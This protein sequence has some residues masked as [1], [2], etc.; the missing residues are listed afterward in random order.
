MRTSRRAFMRAGV[1]TGIAGVLPVGGKAAE[2]GSAARTQLHKALIAPL[3]DD[4]TCARLA[5][6]GFSG[7]ELTKKDVTLEQGV[8]GRLTAEKHGIRI[9]SFMAGWADF[10]QEDEG[11]RNASIEDV[12]RMIRLTAAYGASTMLLVP[13]RIGGMAMPRPTQFQVEFDADTLTVRRVAEGDNAPYE[14]YIRAQNRAT[15]LSRQ[16]IEALLPVAARE[17]VLIAVEN[18]WNNLWVTPELL[19]AFVRSFDS[20]WVKTYFDLGNHVRYAPTEQWLRTLKRVQA[21]IA[22]LHIKDFKIDR[23]KK[24][25][26]DFVPLGQGSVDWPLV[27]RVID[28]IRYD[29]WVTIESGGMT[30]AE[31]S[32]WMDRFFAGQP[33]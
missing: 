7:V 23:E 10:N 33:A 6:A 20:P 25:D 22:K 30:D 8:Q 16:A 31:H 24:N 4:A 18:V 32:A 14:A 3:A 19:G 2:A 28:E 1:A 21:G 12:A 26:G 13:C 27:R 17:G 11:K 9:H 5:A 15:L 29:G